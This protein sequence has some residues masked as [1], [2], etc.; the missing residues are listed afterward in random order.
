MSDALS[1]AAPVPRPRKL[2]PA[3]LEYLRRWPIR[4]SVGAVLVFL[5]APL[6]TLM[7]FSFNNSKANVVWRG[8]TLKYYEKALHND[9]LIQAFSNSM[10][11]AFFLDHPVTDSGGYGCHRPVALPLPRQDGF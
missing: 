10:V 4:L 8:F 9:S 5:Y 6:I 1:T 7:I 3:P 11:I 2:P